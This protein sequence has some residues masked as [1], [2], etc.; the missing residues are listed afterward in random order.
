LRTIAF[1]IVIIFGMQAVSATFF[2]FTTC[3]QLLVKVFNDG[4]PQHPDLLDVG[5]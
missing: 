5:M 1:K 4:V 2:M 3:H